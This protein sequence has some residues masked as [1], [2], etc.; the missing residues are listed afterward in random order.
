MGG[1]GYIRTTVE[2]GMLA[3]YG[4]NGG[5]RVWVREGRNEESRKQGGKEKQMHRKVKL[6][7]I[8]V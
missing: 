5:H 2:F 7:K 3:R 8:P 6:L 1:G 4:E